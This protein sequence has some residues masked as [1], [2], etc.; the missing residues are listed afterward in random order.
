MKTIADFVATLSSD[1]V[2]EATT[3]DGM[4]HFSHENGSPKIVH[5]KNA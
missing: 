5:S 2:R 4:I 1:E 3:K